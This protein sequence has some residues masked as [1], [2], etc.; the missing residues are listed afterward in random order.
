[1]A[2][3]IVQLSA[4]FS[5]GNVASVTSAFG[6]DITA[7]SAII[8]AYSV[9]ND[10]AMTISDNG[11]RSYAADFDFACGLNRLHLH[12]CLGAAAGPCTI[13]IDP[14]GSSYMSGIAIEVAGLKT[15]AAVDDTSGDGNINITSVQPGSIDLAQ[16]EELVM[17][18]MAV[19]ASR[20]I[21]PPA[22]PWVEIAEQQD[23]STHITV[24]VCYHIVTDGA[25]Q[26]PTWTLNSAAT[27]A[28]MQAGY[29]GWTAD[30]VYSG[31]GV[32]RGLSRG[33]Y[34]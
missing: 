24:N 31:R 25:A 33:V 30:E 4:P 8:L 26:N 6:S 21:T 23:Y 5:T 16:A 14:D 1:M 34:R 29:R 10:P 2:I 15:S 7:G 17:G 22:S 12:S 3:S 11:S 28:A 13:T 18:V 32:G 27:M 20:T 19:N 9:Y